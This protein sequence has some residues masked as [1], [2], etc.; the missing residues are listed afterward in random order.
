MIRL[1]KLFVVFMLAALCA[2]DDGTISSQDGSFD[3][4]IPACP[5]GSLGCPCMRNTACDYGLI[6]SGSE[7]VL[8]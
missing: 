4:T 3:G 7:C 6:C 1:A 2:C 8:P 5:P